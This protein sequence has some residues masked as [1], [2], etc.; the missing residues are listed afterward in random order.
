[1]PRDRGRQL[2]D[3]L[4]IDGASNNGVDQVRDLRD[5]VQFAPTRGPFKIY[6]HRRS[7]HAQHG[8]VQRAAEDAGGAAAAREVHLRHHRGQKVLPTIISRCQRFDLRRIQ[9]ALIVERLRQICGPSAVEID[10][11]RAAGRGARGA[12]G[13]MRDARNSALDQLISFKADALT[14]DDVLAVFGLVSRQRMEDLA[15]ALLAG[16]VDAIMVLLDDLDRHGKDMKRVL[17]E[18]LDWFRNLLAWL[19]VPDSARLELPEAAVDPAPAPARAPPTAAPRPRAEAAAHVA[20]APPIAGEM[21]DPV[22]AWPDIAARIS[23]ARPLTGAA[24]N[25][26]SLAMDDPDR[27]RIRIPGL[28]DADRARLEQEIVPPAEKL[29]KKQTGRAIRLSISAA[30]APPAASRPRARPTPADK[31]PVTAP[32]PASNAANAADARNVHKELLENETIQELLKTF[33]GRITDI[34]E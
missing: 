33:D 27:G 31:P 10:R 32:A 20:D 15:R 28:N 12:E 17:Q 34:H 26:S 25:G 30:P 1:V 6:H 11:R 22:L 5:Q 2:L 19:H 29:L 4:E 23:A 21:T 3:V 9:T 16:R 13:G 8:G 7:P 14:E 18:L 24:L